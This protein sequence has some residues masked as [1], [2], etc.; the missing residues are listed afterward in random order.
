MTPRL[1]P[2]RP[3]GVA[4][5][6]ARAA[7]MG[8]WTLG[9]MQ[10]APLH[11][12]SRPEPAQEE[13][14]QDWIK[15]WAR[16]LLQ[17][18]GVRRQLASGRAA[19]STRARLVVAN[20]RS[21][22]D[23]ILMLEHFGGCVL[24]HQGV[25]G[26]PILGAAARQAGTIFVDRS[27]RHS[28]AKAIRA[29]RRR[30]QEGRTVIVFPEGTTFR[31]DEVRP[32]LGG[33]FAAVRGLDAEILPVGIAYDSGSE[34]VDESFGRYLG[35]MAQRSATRVALCIGEPYG[36]GPNREAMGRELQTEVR[37][38]VGRARGVLES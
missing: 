4:L 21:P 22:I 30:L 3:L 11:I 9:A 38:L 17:V 26:W 6:G 35:R 36:A 24:S 14:L 2:R 5:S 29:I 25:A 7:A 32:F 31:G 8:A 18:F 19:P 23:I 10:V 16:G 13:L 28:G 33:A 34:F 12:R 1:D 20:H 27:D 15:L 37:A